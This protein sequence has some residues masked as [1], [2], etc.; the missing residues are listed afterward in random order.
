[1]REKAGN[2]HGSSCSLS[3]WDALVI[4]SQRSC[5]AVIPPDPLET[6]V[7]RSFLFTISI[8]DSAAAPNST[9]P[10]LS[11]SL[12][13]PSL[14]EL[15][16]ARAPLIYSSIVVCRDLLAARRAYNFL[17]RSLSIHQTCYSIA[18][19]TIATLRFLVIVSTGLFPLMYHRLRLQLQPQPQ[20]LD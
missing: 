13:F 2:T 4:D 7:L 8:F 18:I 11:P 9:V 16:R 10:T 20:P 12:P 15:R 6:T 1:M 3:K 19:L 5:Q 17:P 14:A